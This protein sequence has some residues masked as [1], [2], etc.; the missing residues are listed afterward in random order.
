[1]AACILA[2]TACND[3]DNKAETNATGNAK[4]TTA[5][6]AEN[7]NDVTK[8]DAGKTEGAKDTA[9]KTKN[10]PRLPGLS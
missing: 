10:L 9:E 2:L 3:K 1:L 4:D 5:Q 7:K 6:V 8:S